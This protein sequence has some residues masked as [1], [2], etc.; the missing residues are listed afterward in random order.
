MRSTNS[1]TN[2]TRRSANSLSEI[3]ALL[4][5][6]PGKRPM[7]WIEP[8]STSMRFEWIPVMR[9]SSLHDWLIR[10]R[11]TY[12]SMTRRVTS[13]G[14]FSRFLENWIVFNRLCQNTHDERSPISGCSTMRDCCRPVFRLGRGSSS[15]QTSYNRSSSGV[16]DI[17]TPSK[18]MV[19]TDRRRPPSSSHNCRRSAP[20]SDDSRLMSPNVAFRS[21][22]VAFRRSFRG[23]KGDNQQSWRSP[24]RLR[25]DRTPS[26]ARQASIDSLQYHRLSLRESSVPAQLSRSERRL[27]TGCF[28]VLNSEDLVIEDIVRCEKR[29]SIGLQIHVRDFLLV[30]RPLPDSS[31]ARSRSIP[32]LI[33]IA[34]P[35]FGNL[36]VATSLGVGRGLN[37]SLPGVSALVS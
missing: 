21:A 18:A 36:K 13:F 7:N 4:G 30:E 28:G 9:V 25:N 31:T 3:P 29:R 2:S 10:T 14:R 11:A 16:P 23:A 27:S 15:I 19:R 17:L 12:S 37:P 35:S 26:L 1:R 33:A 8:K 22:K 20:H 24:R 6:P 32:R 34:W 5:Q